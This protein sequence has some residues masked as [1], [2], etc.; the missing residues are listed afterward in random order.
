VATTGGETEKR[1]FYVDD[2]VNITVINR[3][4]RILTCVMKNI[5]I[6]RGYLTFL[7]QYFGL[8]LTGY[9]SGV[10]QKTYMHM[11]K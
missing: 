10:E 3:R 9:D 5:L 1:N 6:N 7:R 4:Y 11:W 2:N 8:R